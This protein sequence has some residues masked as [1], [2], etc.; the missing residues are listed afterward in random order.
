[1]VVCC[2]CGVAIQPNDA[3]MC[4]PCLRLEV[5]QETQGSLDS[6]EREIVQCPKC[7]EWKRDNV[8]QNY[9]AAEW[10]SVQLLTHLTKR[11]RRL[12]NLQVVDAKFVW[13]EPHSKR[14]KVHIIYEQEVLDRTKVQQSVELEFRIRDNLCRSCSKNSNK[15]GWSSMVQ[16]RQHADTVGVL[17]RLEHDIQEVGLHLP[18]SQIGSTGSGLDMTFNEDKHANDLVRFVRGRVPCIYQQ[19][20]KVS[21]VLGGERGAFW[22]SISTVDSISG[23]FGC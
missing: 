5:A 20:R 23:T 6:I 9:F 10:E 11:L 14:I 18:A 12:K 2:L 7:L 1:M 17:L 19:T 4:L 15:D 8:S 21:E 3:M 16:I 13:T 22:F